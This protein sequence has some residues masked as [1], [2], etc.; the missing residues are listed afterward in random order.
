MLQ[1][2]GLALQR[3][4]VCRRAAL[5]LES[6]CH[7]YPELFEIAALSRMARPGMIQDPKTLPVSIRI[8][9]QDRFAAIADPP[10][11]MMI[12]QSQ[13]NLQTN[14]PG[15]FTANRLYLLRNVFRSLNQI[16]RAHV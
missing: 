1:P 5:R 4:K 6:L 2:A 9:E 3:G 14:N 12:K 13:M 7:Q 8:V 10:N 11:S 16:G 15:G